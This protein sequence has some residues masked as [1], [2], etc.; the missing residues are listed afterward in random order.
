MY[1]LKPLA[2]L[3][4][5]V[6]LAGCSGLTLPGWIPLAGS[7]EVPLPEPIVEVP[8]SLPVSAGR[9]ISSEKLAA[10]GKLMLIPF[11]AGEHVVA[12]EELDKIAFRLMQGL[13][14][15]LKDKRPFFEIIINSEK[16]GEPDFLVDGYFVRKKESSSFLAKWFFLRK[17]YT[18]GVQ[19]K[20]MDA[21][22]REVIATFEDH[23]TSTDPE[24]DFFQ[25]G[26]DIGQ[27]IGNFIQESI[28]LK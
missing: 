22:T 21:R 20:V 6:F 5:T 17:K 23:L 27:N 9:M 18:L 3:I 24:G 7:K 28:N 14:L 8:V 10:G 2:C 25:L 19:G 13:A 26:F 12:T 1:N 4:L 15:P 16:G 11:R